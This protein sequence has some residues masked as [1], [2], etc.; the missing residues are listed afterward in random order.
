MF[1]INYEPEPTGTA[2]NSTWQTRSLARMGWSV[3]VVTGIPHYPSWTRGATPPDILTGDVRVRRRRHYVPSRMTAAHR[4]LY[5]ATWVA[6]ALPMLLPARRPDA[7]IGVVPSLGGALLAYLASRRYGV[8]YGVVF[9]D[10][11]GRAAA[12]CGIEGASSVSG[13]LIDFELALARRAKAIAVVAEGFV[14]HFADGG[15]PL[16]RIHKIRNPATLGPVTVPRAEMRQRLGWHPNEFIVLHSGSIGFKQGLENMVEAA[17]LAGPDSGI[18]FVLQGDGTRRP[19]LERLVRE[20]GLSNV[21]FL[22]LAAEEEFASILAS[23]DVLL[24][25]QLGSVINMSMPAKLAI[26]FAAGVPVVAA[27]RADD[28]TAADI[29]RADAGA[30]VPPEDPS[31]LLDAIA[32]MRGA[33]ERAAGHGASAQAYARDFL[34]P[35]VVLD[36]L[37]SFVE[38]AAR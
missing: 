5:E 38:A 11:V 8:P 23:A 14:G 9:Q 24:L 37:R 32:A 28:E 15:V 16:D 35:D 12:L 7:I 1:G 10:V 6:S 2:L 22:P 21:T 4:G 25:N 29:A 34:A 31:A 33:P 20:Y 36:R 13:P 27:V 26:Y 19:E 3:D 30:V 18:R 17:R